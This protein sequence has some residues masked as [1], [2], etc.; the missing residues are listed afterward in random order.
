[1]K[2]L[3]APLLCAVLALAGCT[4]S[5]NAQNGQES[6]TTATTTTTSTSTSGPTV[7]LSIRP[8]CLDVA[9]KAKDL[10]TVAG[11][12]AT[13]NATADQVRAAAGELS[14]SFEAAKEAIGPEERAHLDNAGKALQR[15]RDA[16]SVQPI[17]K[18]ALQTAAGDVVAALGDAAAVCAPG[19]S[20]SSTIQSTEDTVTTTS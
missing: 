13:G 7:S 18:G 17:D 8:E 3:F 15:A 4:S 2:R 10:L 1:M 16:L 12:L 9:N 5:T 11:R 6:S 19:S 20:T 14:T